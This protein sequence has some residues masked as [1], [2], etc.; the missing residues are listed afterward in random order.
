MRTLTEKRFWASQCWY[1]AFLLRRTTR[2]VRLSQAGREFLPDAQ[3]LL[4]LAEHVTLQGTRLTDAT[5]GTVR[6][7]S[8][9]PRRGKMDGKGSL[10]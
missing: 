2:S 4:R 6:L 5:I 10:D 1:I 7:D 9:R 3:H 8:S